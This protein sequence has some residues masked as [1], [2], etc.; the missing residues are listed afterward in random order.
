ML[1]IIAFFV[2]A[3]VGSGVAGQIARQYWRKKIRTD[4]RELLIQC[5]SELS[6]E[7]Q[8]R[9]AA[10]ANSRE[11]EQ[12]ITDYREREMHCY[13]QMRSQHNQIESLEQQL[14]LQTKQQQ[15]IQELEDKLD[16]R[17][18]EHLNLVSLAQQ[19][20]QTSI[21]AIQ[22]D[23]DAL[24]RDNTALKE[25]SDCTEKALAAEKSKNNALQEA[26]NDLQRKWSK[27][28][29]DNSAA[30]E[31]RVELE[32]KNRDLLT[33]NGILQKDV[34]K[35]EALIAQKREDA[36]AVNKQS[37]LNLIKV[38]EKLF[39]EIQL[40]HHSKNEIRQHKSKFISLLLSFKHLVN[41]EPLLDH[42]PI[43]G[44][45]YDLCEYRVA[46]QGRVYYY[47]SKLESD[48][49]RYKVVVAW[50][51]NKQEQQ[52]VIDWFNNWLKRHYGSTP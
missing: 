33:K 15:R 25:K 24:L 14:E 49:T 6:A 12:Q 10:E 47:C 40:L 41:K 9:S 26:R 38:V 51:H 29:E 31:I 50:K 8:K 11:L 46:Y 37:G 52:K 1:H 36:K 39:P 13:E 5:E 27:H 44:T 23:Y 20:A 19:E 16:L 21:R 35:L 45:D 28:R 4:K 18:R 48:D 42:K 32:N 2:G 43:Q 22:D 34:K 3:V 7:S 17:E 30:I